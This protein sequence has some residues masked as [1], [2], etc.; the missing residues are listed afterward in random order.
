MS[1]K[2]IP[3]SE[4]KEFKIA[5]NENASH[6]VKL[7]FLNQIWMRYNES[8]PGST[9]YN[10]PKSTTYDIGLRRT[11]F[12]LFGQLSDRVF[13]Y[14]QF[15]LNNISYTSPRKQG[16]FLHDATSEYVVV[17]RALS[18]GVG[19]TGWN[20]VSRYS[21]PSVGSILTMDAPLYQQ[22]T[23]DVNDQFLR[24]L[25]IYAKGKLG[26]LDYRFIL[27][28]PMSVQKASTSGGDFGQNSSFSTLP[29]KMQ[30]HGYVNYQFKEEESNLLPYNVGSYLGKKSVFNI[31]AGFL[32]QPDAMWRQGNNM[33]TL[34]TNLQLYSVD[35]F[36]DLP[37]NSQKKNA[38]TVYASYQYSDYGKNYLRSIGAMNPAT[39]VD[40]NGSING[41]GSACPIIGTGNTLYAQAGYLF[42]QDLLKDKGTLQPFVGIQFSKFDILK[43]PV[44]TIDCGLN[45]LMEGHRSKL[46]LN[47]QNRPVFN[48]D[49]N[50]QN[51]QTSR[52][53]MVVLQYQISL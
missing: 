53:S 40:A 20:G 12:Q 25:S 31:G 32:V 35:V 48:T 26:A 4:S 47:Y 9:V 7:T 29:G 37:L 1:Q 38:I 13:F 21:S 18:M 3:Y 42:K 45:W 39:G 19:L 8:N 49:V 27:S 41:A 44:T 2:N 33:D 52:K 43:D 34:Q 28:N 23:N 17:K 6:Y 5:F 46:S 24:K 36:Y 30:V 22:A 15:G 10:A 14:T 51:V 50:G 16:L 11:R